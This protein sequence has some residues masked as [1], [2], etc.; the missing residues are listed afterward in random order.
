MS[1][2]SSAFELAHEVSA[3]SA[4]AARLRNVLA[5]WARAQGLSAELAED[6]K[7][8]AYEAMTNVIR[9]AY[10][11]GTDNLM[12]V[13]AVR[14]AGWITITVADT[15]SWREGH[16]PGG[17]RGVPIIATFAPKSSVTTTSAGTTVSVSW[18]LAH[19]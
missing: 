12:T 17:G 8:T 15:G 2:D 11:G 4:Q 5:E 3:V 10:A 9:H 16:R 13:T 6:V 14:A 18:P 19:H 7:L 1:A